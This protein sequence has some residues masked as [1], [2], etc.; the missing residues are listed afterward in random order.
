LQLSL[1]KVIVLIYACVLG[2]AGKTTLSKKDCRICSGPLVLH[3]LVVVHHFMYHIPHIIPSQHMCDVGPIMMTLMTRGRVIS[4]SDVRQMISECGGA[5]SRWCDR[6]SN[7]RREGKKP[8]DCSCNCARPS[9]AARAPDSCFPTPTL[10]PAPLCPFVELDV[11]GNE[12]IDGPTPLAAVRHSDV[13]FCG[14]FRDD[15]LQ[16]LFD[17][18]ISLALRLVFW[19]QLR[20]MTT[21]LCN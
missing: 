20:D 19:F 17:R 14:T 2:T 21:E 15:R 13:R 11:S 8:V 5:G 3:R 6:A 18:Q 9:A 10:T 7:T 1:P 12:P 16:R 4:A